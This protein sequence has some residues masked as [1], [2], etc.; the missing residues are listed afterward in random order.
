[1]PGR[2][3]AESLEAVARPLRGLSGMVWMIA[4]A[5]GAAAVF[6]VVA[7]LARAGWMTAPVWVLLAWL[8]SIAMVFAGVFAARAALGRFGPWEI[9]R[10]LEESGGWRRGSLTTTLER[11]AEGTSGALHASAASR[12]ADDVL[13][14]GPAVLGPAT[15]RARSVARRGAAMLALALIGLAAARPA[16]GAPATI[17]HPVAAWRA[18]V[19][20]VRLTARATTVDRG[21]RGTLDLT[22]IGH[23]RAVL[24]MRSPGEAWRTASVMLDANGQATFTT[25]P[26]AAELVAR[27]E[28]GGRRSAEV[29]IG[30]RLAAFL[31]AFT[32]T[33][34]YPAYLGLDDESLPTAGDTLVLPEGTRL[35][36]AGRA[37]TPVASARLSGPDGVLPLDVN[38]P[39]FRGELHPRQSGLWR[40]AVMLGND[41]RLQGEMPVVPVRIVADSAPTVEIPV[42][43]ADT[44]ATASMSLALVVSLRDDHGLSGAALELRRG[45]STGATRLPL[46]LPAGGGARA[47][48]TTAI[49]LGALRLSPGDTLR[50]GATATDNAP[51]RHLGRSR[52][53]VVRIPTAAEERA[54]RTRE[55]AA[56]ATA[57]DSLTQQAGRVQRTEEDLARERQRTDPGAVDGRTGDAAAKD[58]L[59]SEAARRAEAAAQAQQRVLDDAIKIQKE[60]QE[61]RA[62]AERQGVSDSALTRELSEINQLLDKALSPE[63]RARLAALQQAVKDLDADRTRDALQ[64]LARQQAMLKEA[65]DQARELFKRAALESDLANMA[66]DARQLA[67]EQQALTPK[68]ATG[69]SGRAAHTETGLARRADSLGEGLD[70]A[71][72]KVPA[73]QPRNGLQQAAQQAHDAASRLR[74]AAQS[75]TDGKP[76]AAEAA[77]K[78][79]EDELNPLSKQIDDNRQNMQAE[80]RAEVKQALERALEETS[81]L[82]TRQLAV[83]QA[84]QDGALVP[85]TRIDQGLVEEGVGKV[86]Q[87]VAAV[88]AMN[89]LVSPQAAAALAEARRLMGATIDAVASV[90]P[91]VRD[92]VGK[93]GD[94]VDALA[95]AAYSLMQS[96]DRVNGSQS[97]SGVQEAMEQMKQ[98][99]GKQGQLAQQGAGMMQPGGM[100][101]QQLMQMALQQR[102]LAQQLERMR[103]AGQLPGAGEM[104]REAKDLAKTLAGGRL[105]QDIVNRQQQLFHHMLDAGRT[106]QGEE[107]DEKRER[108]S[109]TALD[110]PP[111]IP[112]PLDPRIRNGSGEIRLPGWDALQRL[113]PDERRRVV[114]YFQRLT[115]APV[116]P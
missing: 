81:D 111:A 24:F 60:V 43:G 88:A 7:W 52:E 37:T 105:N 21:E 87:Q 80:M 16:T 103:A 13:D 112:P 65:M 94:A 41:V 38:G 116:R 11:P 53:F 47:L 20:P 5:S 85:Q 44:V 31:G 49:D 107:D 74:E 6:A 68:L 64:D 71:A 61:L 67:S 1:M 70:R 36:V 89:A 29:R 4:G 90:N 93:S 92:A 98:M 114:D 102:A 100:N 34:H 95:V 15:R 83:A 18:M 48:I 76:A 45:N 10:R 19:A 9:G 46:T 3:L 35:S 115:Q 40:L 50:Y 22:A 30:V 91:N 101:A 110:A 23:R 62:A 14:R 82:A 113:S 73:Q 55:T 69:D 75:S 57:F 66:Q 108:Q 106:L 84:I 17:W 33:A 109:T 72:R 51:A 59:A 27:V 42:P 8:L 96:K 58:P 63:L 79:A 39:G 32:V 77:G 28:A 25:P 12:R 99:A 86:M 104:G 26:L 56:A 97:G 54:A 2:S 78:Q